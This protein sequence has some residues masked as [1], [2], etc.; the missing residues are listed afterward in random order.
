MAAKTE[1]E[2]SV[3]TEQNTKAEIKYLLSDFYENPGVLGTTQD[4]VMAAFNYN[5]I[6]SAT[7]KE[8]QKIVN[9]FKGRKVTC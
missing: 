6:T 5:G 3:K 9:E 8:A 4:I 1:V 7:V 2:K